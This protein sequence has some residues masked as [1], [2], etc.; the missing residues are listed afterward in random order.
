MSERKRAVLCFLGFIAFIGVAM[1]DRF[2]TIIDSIPES[3]AYYA[4]IVPLAG[5]AILGF[6][7]WWQHYNGRKLNPTVNRMRKLLEGPAWWNWPF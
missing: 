7:S 6:Y 5:V 4:F 3:L 2:Q 1:S